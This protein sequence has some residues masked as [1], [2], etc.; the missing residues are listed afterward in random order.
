MGDHT[1]SIQID[2]DPEKTTYRKLLK[3]FWTSHSVTGHNWS[4]QYMSAIWYNS[5]EQQQDI[6]KSKAKHQRRLSRQGKSNITTTIGKLGPFTLAEDY[7]QKWYLRKHDSLIQ[8]L[9]CT[10]MELIHSHAATR[11]NAYVAG[12]GN[13]EQLMAEIDGFELP[14]EAKEFVSGLV[15]N[16]RGKGFFCSG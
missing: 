16:Q 12:K 7:H 1:E 2:F 11:L 10:E 4:R 3:I 9:K 13:Y 15:K 5:K 8:A 14:E 6:E